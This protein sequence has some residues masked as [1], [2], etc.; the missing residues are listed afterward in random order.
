[1]AEPIQLSPEEVRTAAENGRAVVDGLLSEAG[2]RV[3]EADYWAYYYEHPDFSYEWNNGILEEKPVADVS[4]ADLYRWFLILLNAFLEAQPIARMVN[5]EIGFRL[6][7]PDKT[8]IRKPDLF[9]VRNDNP[10]PLH[11]S[12]RT[13]A[14]ICDLCVES[15]SDSTTQEIERDTKTKKAEY[16]GVGV[17]EYYILDA[18]GKYTAFYRRTPDGDYAPIHTGR[19]KVIRSQVLPGFQFR[20][21]DLYRQP[22][23]IE[24]TEDPVYQQYV[25]L[26]YQ[27]ERRRAD[28]ERARAD[29]LAA[30]LRE[31][32]IDEN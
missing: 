19:D 24:L 22:A 12:D 10:V 3:S 30:R 1:M 23:L 8:T 7:L 26:E 6:A 28:Q 27:A 21:A 4:N 32:G 31:L 18:S 17:H 5:L 20:L 13:Y 25:L 16:E 15:L 2:K 11:D 9:V 29:R 14:G